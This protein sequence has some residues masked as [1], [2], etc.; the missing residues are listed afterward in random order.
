MQPI[1]IYI[2][3]KFYLPKVIIHK[4]NN[5]KSEKE[6]KKPTFKTIAISL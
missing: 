3:L 5:A 2:Q 6:I 1:H 4:F